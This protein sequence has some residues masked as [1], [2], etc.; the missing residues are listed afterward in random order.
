MSRRGQGREHGTSACYVWGPEPGAGKG[1]RC[2]ACRTARA[3][4]ERDRK[5][6]IAPSYVA[7]DRAR[8]H[9]EEL[10]AAGVGLKTIS[11]RSGISHGTL[12]KLVYG[13][14][15]R[16][17]GP[18]K[19]IRKATEDAILAVMPADAAD[20]A[21]VF[22]GPTWEIVDQLLK[23]G[24]TKSAI[25]A[26]IGQGGVA[27]QLGRRF[28][29]AGNA[30]AVKALL[31]QPVPPRRSR[32]GL[33]VVA[34]PDPDVEMRNAARR[35]RD[36]ERKAAERGTVHDPYQ[37]PSLEGEGPTDWMRRGACRRPEVPNWLF[38]PGRG[39]TET[40]VRAKAVCS[41]CS[42]SDD[43]LAY[44]LLNDERGIWGGTSQKQRQAMQR[45]RREG[46]A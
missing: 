46:V 16:N 24:W 34:E 9:V 45:R 3:V 2:D 10:M 15:T 19:R 39:D 7:A 31:D 33:H 1:C 21:R 8:A 17:M 28:V 6:R 12:S 32:W 25:S 40:V 44:A 43:C 4:Y 36:A 23:R 26:A 37:L 42:V 22:A 11:A 14:R 5:R 30:R 41:T 20:G 18:S 29:T 38:F 35:Q 27:L 13:D